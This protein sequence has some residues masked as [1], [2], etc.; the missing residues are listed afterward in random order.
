LFPKIR[1]SFL[2]LLLGIKIISFLAN[3][4]SEHKFRTFLRAWFGICLPSQL[5]FAFHR[6]NFVL[7]AVN[8]GLLIQVSP[9]PSLFLAHTCCAHCLQIATKLNWTSS[10]QRSLAASI[11]ECHS[12]HPRW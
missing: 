5:Y 10:C 11:A 3:E 8:S 9:I 2:H 4:M 7:V 1:Y 6:G 12:A